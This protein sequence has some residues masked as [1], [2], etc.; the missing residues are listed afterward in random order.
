MT[1]QPLRSTWTRYGA[2]VGFTALALA[3]KLLLVPLVT[4]DAPFLLFFASVLA[5][6]WYGGPG[7]GLLGPPRPPVPTRW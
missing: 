5:S 4:S 6:A 1:R 3:I 2:A 7:P